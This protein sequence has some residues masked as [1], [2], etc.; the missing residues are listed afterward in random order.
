MNRFANKSKFSPFYA[1]LQLPGIS[2]NTVHVDGSSIVINAQIKGKYGVCPVCGKKSHQLHST[3]YRN[4]QDLSVFSKPVSI[5]LLIKK[6]KC[7]NLQCERKIFSQQLSSGFDRYSRRTKRANEQITQMSLEMSARKSSW[8]SNLQGLPV[9]PSTCLR[10]TGKCDISIENHIRH[11]GIDDWAYRK[12]HTYGTILVDRETGKAVDLIRSRDKEDI[13]KWLKSHPNIESVT[14][15]R[16]ECYSRSISLALPN[17]VQIADRFHL[18]VN[19]SDYVVRIIQKLIPELKRIKQEEK[20]SKNKISDPGI[21]RIIDLTFGGTSVLKEQK[22]DL[23]LK[24]KELYEE[25]HSKCMVA[26]ILNLNFRTVS[27]YIDNNPNHI[28]AGTNPRID[29]ISY[30][31]DLTTGYCQGEKLSVVYR[32]MKKKGFRGTQR[33]LSARFG[34][35]Y[36]EGKLTN[37]A[38]TFGNMKRKCLPQTISSRKLAIYLTNKDYGKILLPGEIETFNMFRNNNPLLNELWNISVKC[39]DVFEN[40]SISM[41][42]EWIDQVMNSSFKSLKCFVKGLIKDWEAIKASILYTD[43][44]GITEGNVNRLKNIKRQMYGRAGFELLRRKVVLSNTG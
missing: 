9:S 32:R 11:L 6:F 21:Q 25:G 5:K 4:L 31:E 27:K 13:V 29:Y 8:V 44:N 37:S 19:Y 22:K 36:R 23:I 34:T 28:N 16:A 40:K 7:I 2:I 20:T 26:K 41:F 39:R 30:I 43:N 35:I 17:A 42:Q 38:V 24:A 18:A 33:G 1:L 12:G 14:R 3:Y 15:D 10:L